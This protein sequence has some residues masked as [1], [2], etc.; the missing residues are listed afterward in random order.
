[1]QI[2]SLTTRKAMTAKTT[3]IFTFECF[4]GFLVLHNATF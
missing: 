1:M 4:L 3:G 2:L